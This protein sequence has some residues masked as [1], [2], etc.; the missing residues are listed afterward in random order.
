MYVKIAASHIVRSCIY[1]LPAHILQNFDQ[2]LH[3]R[4]VGSACCPLLNGRERKDF[5]YH[6]WLNP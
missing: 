3:F 4:M 6:P 5:V 1:T 2:M